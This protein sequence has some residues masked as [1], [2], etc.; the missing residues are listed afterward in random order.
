MW[1][2]RPSGRSVAIW[3]PLNLSVFFAAI[4]L[5]AAD[6][7]Q[8]EE[9][10]MRAAVEAVAP[11]V[12]RIETFGGLQRVGRVLVGSG[13]T[14]GLIVSEDGFI[15][16][17]AFNFVQKPTSILVTLDNGTRAPATIVARDHSRMLV[18]LKVRTDEKL[19]VP[20]EVARDQVHVGQWALAVGRTLE[21]G[22]T[23]VSVN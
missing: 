7:Q 5:R 16:S 21:G 12:V 3:L 14:T 6:V 9:M 15:V 23:S 19:F 20:P 4:A 11:A 8:L 17:S 13:P 10:A 2:Y 18:L 22:D 1:C